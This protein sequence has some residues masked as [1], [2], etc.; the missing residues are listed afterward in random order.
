MTTAPL[1]WRY[2]R[3][4]LLAD[5]DRCLGQPAAWENTN[6]PALYEGAKAKL[7]QCVAIDECSA[8]KDEAAGLAAYAKQTHDD[9]LFVLAKRIQ[10]RAYQCGELL[11]KIP[12]AH[13]ANQNIREGD[14]KK[15][16][17]ESAATE[18]GLS[19][20]QRRTAL[21]L[22]AVDEAYFNSSV[23]SEH[24][25]TVTQMASE[26]QSIFYSVVLKRQISKRERWGWPRDGSV[27]HVQHFA[28]FL[29]VPRPVL[30]GGQR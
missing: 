8:W 3:D 14:L 28:S 17:R 15:V 21:L 26:Y 19:E 12:P 13:G 7:A 10:L 5:V 6:F 20:H 2:Q 22:A 30:L 27:T 9:S 29:R 18:A 11:Q 4:H 25:P 23:E 16:T 1:I 24:P